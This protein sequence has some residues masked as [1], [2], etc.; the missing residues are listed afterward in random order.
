MVI[1][2]TWFYYLWFFV[3]EG[4]ELENAIIM[5]WSSLKHPSNHAFIHQGSWQRTKY[6]NYSNV[7]KY[8]FYNVD[9]TG[10]MYGCFI[11]ILS[12]SIF[13]SLTT[14]PPSRARTHARTHTHTHTQIRKMTQQQHHD[15]DRCTSQWCKFVCSA[16]YDFD[17][18]VCAYH[19]M[20]LINVIMMLRCWDICCFI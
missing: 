3:S 11:F 5:C 10:I 9:N 8:M 18:F 12:C 1:Y 16:L 19:I 6:I 20:T 15:L 2:D 14:T 4:F 13:V 17:V 7:E